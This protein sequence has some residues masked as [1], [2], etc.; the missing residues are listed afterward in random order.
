MNKKSY[1][2]AQKRVKKKK[3]FYKNFVTW[4][5]VCFGLFFIN[6][7]NYH[8][9]WWAIYPFLGWGI[10][11]LFQAFDVFGFPGHG[12]D[13]EARELEKEMTRMKMR[14]DRGLRDLPAPEDRMDEILDLDDF[15]RPQRQREER[16]RDE[17]FV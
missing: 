10:G 14:K 2:A 1:K 15:D 11:V 8:G 17:D 16:W 5:V 12:V 4:L 7:M 3:E 9:N 6:A 13:W